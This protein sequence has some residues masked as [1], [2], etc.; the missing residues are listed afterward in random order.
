[1]PNDGSIYEN[2][3]TMDVYQTSGEHV[4]L[5]NRVHAPSIT[6]L[7]DYP[8]GNSRC[9]CLVDGEYGNGQCYSTSSGIVAM[10]LQYPVQFDFHSLRTRWVQNTPSSYRPTAFSVHACTDATEA[11]TTDRNEPRAQR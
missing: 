7:N 3:F 4:A 8:H 9:A 11:T 6:C 2:I 10:R 5:D 1:M